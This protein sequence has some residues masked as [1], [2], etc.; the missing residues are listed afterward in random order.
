MYSNLS[1]A[2]VVGLLAVVPALFAPV[3]ASNEQ[4]D[5]H[6]RSKP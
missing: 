1:I 5:I 6:C 4:K 3:N 2:S